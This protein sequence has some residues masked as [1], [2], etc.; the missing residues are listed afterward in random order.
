MALRTQVTKLQ[1]QAGWSR[2]HSL[3]PCEWKMRYADEY[4]SH[5][6]FHYNIT[7]IVFCIFMGIQLFQLYGMVSYYLKKMI[8]VMSASPLMWH[9]RN[10]WLSC[11]I[12]HAFKICGC[13]M[14]WVVLNFFLHFYSIKTWIDLLWFICTC[15]Y[16]FFLI[17][18]FVHLYCSKSRIVMTK[19]NWPWCVQVG[20][21]IRNTVISL[22]YMICKPSGLHYV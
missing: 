19:I 6:L 11:A 15:I 8:C 13:F 20:V 3:S 17:H 12:Q 2:H 1:I 16:F 18:C 9:E 10:C 22:Q 4:Y 7:C 21:G 5:P 14:L